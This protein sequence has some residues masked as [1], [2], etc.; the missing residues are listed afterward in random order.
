MVN[1]GV[2]CISLQ[3]H[4]SI[5]WMYHSLFNGLHVDRQLGCF[6]SLVIKTRAVMHT[7]EYTISHS[8]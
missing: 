7:L 6:Q 1:S 3:P 5:L 8:F 4:V 2:S